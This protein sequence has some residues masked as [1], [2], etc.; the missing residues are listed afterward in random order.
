MSSSYK[1]E[2]QSDLLIG[3][4]I[5]Q[6]ADLENMLK[7]EKA[8]ILAARDGDY[9]RVLKINSEREA[10]HEKIETFQHQISNLRERL[11]KNVDLFWESEIM[12]RM[13]EVIHLF[14]SPSENRLHMGDIARKK[15][16]E[17]MNSSSPTHSNSSLKLDKK[18]K[19]LT[20]DGAF[21]G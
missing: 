20:F 9:E 1:I 21:T 3:L 7:L 18:Q 5:T 15:S 12:T 17:D 16:I 4:F 10:L 6:C 14:N 19:S 13:C 11:G 8:C 2:K